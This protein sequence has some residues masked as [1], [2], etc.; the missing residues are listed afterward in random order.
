M[1]QAALWTTI[2]DNYLDEHYRC[3]QCA[4]LLGKGVALLLG[5]REVRQRSGNH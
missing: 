2:L 5:H 3:R 4:H 1:L